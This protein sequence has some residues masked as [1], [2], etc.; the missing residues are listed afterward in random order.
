VTWL[1]SDP[2]LMRGGAGSDSMR[3]EITRYR[4]ND[5]S[6]DVQTPVPALLRL[7]DQWYPD[8]VATVDG[9]PTSILRADYL[10]RAVAVPAGRH[11]VEFQFV[12]KAVRT[13]LLLSIAS[14]VVA[15]AL[16][17]AGLWWARRPVAPGVPS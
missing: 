7:A 2:H 14:A 9:K 15:L 1:E 10:L 13:G 17:A 6:I 16:I 11:R 4:L 8:W 12:S 5:V 3:A